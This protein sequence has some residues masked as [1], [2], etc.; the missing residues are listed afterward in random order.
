MGAEVQREPIG[1]E[2]G[3]EP[4]MR[5]YIDQA[6]KLRQAGPALRLAPPYPSVIIPQAIFR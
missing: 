4:E 5:G 3:P 2:M 1:L 6:T